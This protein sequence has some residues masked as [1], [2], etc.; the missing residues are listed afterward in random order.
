[1]VFIEQLFRQSPHTTPSASR[2]E[3][4]AKLKSKQ[5]VDP[6]K[7]DGL[8]RASVRPLRR[9]KGGCVHGS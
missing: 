2:S 6:G 7:A 8:T 1:M 4:N 3:L 5:H 9:R